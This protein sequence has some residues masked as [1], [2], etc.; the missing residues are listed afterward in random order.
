MALWVLYN[1]HGEC[2]VNRSR[3]IPIFVILFECAFTGST[4]KQGFMTGQIEGVFVCFLGLP[5]NNTR[6]RFCTY[7]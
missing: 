1:R 3:G 7:C 6:K 5:V 2:M 4:E